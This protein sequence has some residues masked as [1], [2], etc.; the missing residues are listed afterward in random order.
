MENRFRILD[1]DI[2]SLWQRRSQ[3]VFEQIERH[4]RS[5]PPE[6]IATT[7]VT[8]WEQLGSRFNQVNVG[9]DELKKR[10]K[11]DK[12]IYAYNYLGET[13]EFFTQINILPFNESAAAKFQ[14]LPPRLRQRIG[15][16]DA[17]IAAIVL[18]VGG[19][20]VTRNLRDFSQVPDL[21]IEDWTREGS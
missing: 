17:C 20:L 11:Y 3:P 21:I 5:F 19:V 13:L 6:Q 18:S 2:L 7:I 10:G 16:C 1:T 15:T 4:L 14:E 8:V 9:F 12:L